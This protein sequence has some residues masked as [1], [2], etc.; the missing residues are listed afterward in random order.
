MARRVGAMF[1]MLV[2][3]GLAL[4]LMW[5]VHVH[6][7]QTGGEDDEPSVIACQVL[8]SAEKFTRLPA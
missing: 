5:R 8:S 1:G 7:Q 3:V 4:F 2:I 6:H